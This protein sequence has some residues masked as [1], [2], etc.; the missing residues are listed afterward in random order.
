MEAEIQVMFSAETIN[1]SWNLPPRAILQQEHNR[2][3][4]QSCEKI[5]GVRLHTSNSCFF[6]TST[7]RV[8]AH[9]SIHQRTYIH[10]GEYENEAQP[11]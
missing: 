6:V 9:T 3:E 8:L 11:E 1:E 7:S 2:R 5:F 4:K 10:H